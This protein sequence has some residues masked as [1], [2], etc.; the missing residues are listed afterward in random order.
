MNVDTALD[1]LTLEH[2]VK[3][4][5]RKQDENENAIRWLTEMI[6][7]MRTDEK[8]EPGKAGT[9]MGVC[10]VCDTRR[11]CDLDGIVLPH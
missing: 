7:S 4:L 2:A 8:R 10:P 5:R 11:T 3:I 6:S 1:I 9:C